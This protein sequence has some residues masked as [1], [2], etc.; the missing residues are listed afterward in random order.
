M[1]LAARQISEDNPESGTR[2]AV[3]ITHLTVE[4]RNDKGKPEV[5]NR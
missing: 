2:C 3:L 4:S 5:S 1:P